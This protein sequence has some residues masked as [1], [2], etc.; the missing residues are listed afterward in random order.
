MFSLFIDLNGKS[1][2]KFGGYD[3]GGIKANHSFNNMN[4]NSNSSWVFNLTEINLA[5]V[6]FTGYGDEAP[7]AD[8]KK[9]LAKFNPA[10]PW[11]YLPSDDWTKF[12]Q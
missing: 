10:F 9:S 12:T 11:V 7:Q 2:I 5:T 4:S 8:A 6:H 1:S 3:V